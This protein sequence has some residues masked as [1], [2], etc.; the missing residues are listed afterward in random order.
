MIGDDQERFEDYLEL[1]R[2]IEELQA[3]RVAHPPRDLTPGQAKIYR[4]AALFRSASAESAEPRPEFVEQLKARLLALDEVGQEQE[5]PT[6]ELPGLG[7]PVEPEQIPATK[8]QQVPQI[9]QPLPQKKGMPQRARFVSRRSLLSGGAVAAASLL[10]GAAVGAA[11]DQLAHHSSPPGPNGSST[12]Y[13]PTPLVPSDISTIWLPVATLAELGDDAKR[14][15]SDIVIGYVIRNDG[16]DKEEG[17]PAKEP[18]IAFSAACTH[19]GCIVQWNNGDR[20]FHCPCHNGR[21]TEYGK[22]DNSPGG[23]L[24]LTALPR[25]NVKVDSDGKVYV[26]V[27]K[28]TS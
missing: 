2:Y 5:E 12:L 23:R 22:P 10:A 11:A 13:N 8:E 24:Y 21:F 26:Q 16:D 28:K 9:P 7:K 25:L 19:M 14:F 4:M 17:N 18:V 27:P 1:E 6:Q 3:G 15:V 20:Q